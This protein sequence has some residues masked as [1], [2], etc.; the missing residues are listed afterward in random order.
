MSI[1][2][3][4]AKAADVSPVSLME[5]T[6]MGQIVPGKDLD[7]FRESLI[8][9]LVESAKPNSP[10]TA[11]G[12]RVTQILQMCAIHLRTAFTAS[13]FASLEIRDVGRVYESLFGKFDTQKWPT[14]RSKVAEVHNQE[15]ERDTSLDAGNNLPR[16]PFGLGS[17]P[18]WG[19]SSVCTVGGHPLE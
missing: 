1:L 7:R 8:D 15:Q 11:P 5:M 12:H 10:T 19:G 18:T 3:L 4:V 13:N 17:T 6:Q 16:E 2:Q 14:V 9:L